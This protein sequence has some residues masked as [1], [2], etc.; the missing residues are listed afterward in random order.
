M[1]VRTGQP[2]VTGM[3]SNLSLHGSFL[4]R[5]AFK[6][7]QIN[8]RSPWHGRCEDFHRRTNKVATK[9]KPTR[10]MKLKNLI[11]LLP[12][13]G[14][15]GA[16]PSQPPGPARGQRIL[17]A[18][19]YEDARKLISKTLVC[20]GYEVDTAADGEAAW[21][22]LQHEHY[23]LLV[24]DN[25]MPRLAGME[26]VERI[27]KAGM[28]L[29]I[30]M[31]SGALPEKGLRDHEHLQ[32]AAAF[33]KPFDFWDFLHAVGKALRESVEGVTDGHGNFASAPLPLSL[34]QA[35]ADR[36]AHNRVL[37]AD[38]DP[39]VRGSLAAVL[40]SEGYVVDEARNGIEAVTRAIQNAPDLVL[41]DLNMPH[42]D[43][44]NAFSQLDWVTP[45]LPVIVI[46][47]RPNQYQEAVRLG[48]DGFMEKPLNIPILVRAVKRFTSGDESRHARR[49]TDPAFVTRLLDNNYS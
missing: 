16:D 40:E 43:G 30:I 10:N 8:I 33:T 36:T 4:S 13:N 34:P 3:A 24:T 26:L 18:D 48:V 2:L 37:I 9:T 6:L 42:C 17:V 35:K 46:T 39:T 31:A 47:A 15:S 41:L 12:R 27:R 14:S 7:L 23:D 1:P 20:A 38:D 22:A 21:E 19:D 45:L 28:S 25:E 49:I 29:P 11:P 32:I 5:F 44:W